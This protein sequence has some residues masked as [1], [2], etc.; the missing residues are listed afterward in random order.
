MIGARPSRWWILAIPFAI[1]LMLAASGYRVG[2]FWFHN[3]QHG[4]S[5]LTGHLADCS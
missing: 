3:G 5:N 4:S 2:T 1:A